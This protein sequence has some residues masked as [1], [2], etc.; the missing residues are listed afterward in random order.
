MDIAINVILGLGLCLIIGV[1][2]HIIYTSYKDREWRRNNP[3]EHDILNRKI[4]DD[5]SN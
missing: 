1:V 2:Y 5:F 3:D 4:K